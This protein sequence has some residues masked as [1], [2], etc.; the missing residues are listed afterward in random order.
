MESSTQTDSQ[1]KIWAGRGAS[2]LVILFML[3]DGII[4]L[5]K[6]YIWPCS[7]G[8]GFICATSGCAR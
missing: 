1:T 8:A 5:L 7:C 3:F 6:P 2:A 4:K